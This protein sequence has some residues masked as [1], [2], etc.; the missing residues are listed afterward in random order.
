MPQYIKTFLFAFMV[1]ILASTV[2][3]QDEPESSAK[4]PTP[5]PV[6]P[7]SMED[8]AMP[9]ELMLSAPDCVDRLVDKGDSLKEAKKFCEKRYDRESKRTERIAKEWRKA[10][11]PKVIVSGGD[12][13]VSRSG[14]YP[15][16][17]YSFAERV[18]S[19]RRIGNQRSAGYLMTSSR[20][21]TTSSDLYAGRTYARAINGSAPTTSGSTTVPQNTNRA[22]FRTPN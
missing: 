2:S 3:A 15:S 20:G 17:S 14:Y 10:H 9:S 4:Q 7:T 16:T 1:A 5:L 13:Y 21:V 6:L 18:R 11:Q 22:T 8:V 19:Y 12:G